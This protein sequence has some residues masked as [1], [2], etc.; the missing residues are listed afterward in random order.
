MVQGNLSARTYAWTSTSYHIRKNSDGLKNYK[1]I[2]Y[3]VCISQWALMKLNRKPKSF[4]KDKHVWHHKEKKKCMTNDAI[5]KA[6][7]Q[8]TRKKVCNACG[9]ESKL[10]SY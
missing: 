5:N 1:N 10:P 4:E 8:E 6:K 9:K 2:Y 7:V 3:Y